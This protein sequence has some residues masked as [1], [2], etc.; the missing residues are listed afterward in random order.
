MPAALPTPSSD[1]RER[2]MD[3]A[4][5]SMMHNM[6]QQ[7]PAVQRTLSMR[8]GVVTMSSSSTSI[9]W[10]LTML[11]EQ[12]A[13]TVDWQELGIFN[14]LRSKKL[15]WLQNITV[16]APLVVGGGPR[17]GPSPIVLQPRS[18]QATEPI[19]FTRCT[20]VE[21]PGGDPHDRQAAPIPA[22]P[23]MDRQW[24]QEWGARVQRA[25]QGEYVR[26]GG[27]MYTLEDGGLTVRGGGKEGPIFPD[28]AP[29]LHQLNYLRDQEK[30]LS[31]GG[32]DQQ[33]QIGRSGGGAPPP[34]PPPSGGPDNNDSDGSNKGNTPSW[35]GTVVG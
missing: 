13:Q 10:E 3:F 6:S 31:Q 17:G 20:P 16:L 4:M 1:I 30:P 9:L 29:P 26:P 2:F 24:I 28:K 23:S 8:F 14:G 35:A 11:D 34:P 22:T 15:S 33:G 5:M 7:A 18:W 21:V 12:D 32:R 25:E 19:S 27:G